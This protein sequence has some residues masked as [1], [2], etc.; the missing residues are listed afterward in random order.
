MDPGETGPSPAADLNIPDCSTQLVGVSVEVRDCVASTNTLALESAVDGHVFVADRQTGG[1]G[2]HGHSWHS[3]PGLG[4][5]FSVAL[6]GPPDALTFA[7]ALAVR[8]ALQDAIPASIKWPNDILCEG[9][10]ICGILVEHRA[11]RSALGIGLNVHHQQQDFPEELHATAGSLR[12]ARDQAWH[13]GAVLASVLKELDRRV[14]Q[15]RADGSASLQGE[16]AAACAILGCS[17]RRGGIAG[18]V[19]EIAADG[20]LLV[21]TARGMKRITDAVRVDED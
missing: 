9:R 3:A 6:A 21:E 15:L 14:L 12:M 8:D 1:R 16:W 18:T 13:R 20:A 7:A 5:W 10:K 19:R 2:R 4:L 17:V 11:G